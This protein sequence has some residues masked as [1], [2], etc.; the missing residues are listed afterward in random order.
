MKFLSIYILLL[1][2]TVNAQFTEF[3]PELDWFTIK[4]KYVDVHYHSEAERTARTVAKIADEVWEPI[5]S[6]YGYEP[7]RVHF[8]IKD[9]DDYSN[10]AAYFFDNKIEIWTSAL[11]FDLRG[12][13]NWLRNVISHEFTHMVQIQASLKFSRSIPAVYLQWLNYEDERRP[14]I[15]YGFPNIIMSYPYAFV[16]IPAWYAEGTAQY[17]RKE[18]GYDYWDAHRDMILRSY[19]LD[20]NL[21]TWNQMGVFGKTSLGNESAY[22]AGFA[23]IKYIAQKYGEA[24]LV[25]INNALRKLKNITIDGA[26][27]D[28]LGISGEELYNEWREFIINDYKKRTASVIE[29]K[30]EGEMIASVGFGN[31]HP[32]FSEDGKKVFYISNKNGDYF[33]SSGIYQF[34]I[35]T[36]N[37]ELIV[38]GVRSTFD[39]IPG[40]NKIIFSK[41]SDDNPHW[42]NVNDLYVYDINTKKQ[43]RLTYN[44]RA[45][46]PSVSPDGKNIIF[47][48]QR[49]GSTNLGTVD[50]EGKNFRQIT[51]YQYGEQV[52]NPKF[53]PDNKLIIFDYSFEDARKIATIKFD[54][55]DLKFI[56]ESKHDE[57]NA[58][59]DKEGNIIYSSN[60]TGIFNIY[61]LNINSNEKTQLTNV[62]GGAF[63]PS[64]NKEGNITYAGYTSTGYKIFHLE[65][66]SRQ[67]INKE[68]NYV[69]IENPPLGKDKP[70]GDLEKFDL[71]SL[72]KYNDKILPE[73]DKVKYG[74]AF[75]KLTVFPF[76]RY[77]NYNP[78]NTAIE[79]IKPGVYL[80]SSDML[81][82]Y[83]F[84]AGGAINSRMERDLFLIFDYKNKLPI[85]YSL[86]IKPEVSIELYNITRKADVDVLLNPDTVGNIVKY[87][88]SIPTDVTYNLF[89]FDFVAKHRMFSRNDELEFRFIFSRYNAAIGSFFIPNLGLYPTT[90]DT[91]LIG[92]NFQ[93]K[94]NFASIKPSVDMNI[95]PV[96]SELELIYNYELNKFNIDN[97]YTVEDGI[98]KSVFQ[99]FNFHR[100]ELNSKLHFEVFKNHTLTTRVR[101][102]TVLGPEVPDFFDFYLGGL[103]GMKSYPFYA[104]S[105]NEVG[106]FNITYRF[107]LFRNIDSRVGHLYIDKIFFSL[108]GDIGNAWTGEIPKLNEFKKGA[109]AEL[110]IGLNSFYLFPTSVFINASYG[111]DKV[112]RIVRDEL[113]TYG[114]EFRF[115]G[116]ILFG[117]DF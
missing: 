112:E 65:N 102:G 57:R 12:T 87:D 105:G 47:V 16:N 41:L 62:T 96:G 52:Y 27:K 14:D 94:Y 83:S 98:L 36:K 5:T 59:Y 91:Y 90:D 23:L 35:E 97:E 3:H 110:R 101:A 74:G 95:N 116:G 11:D 111:F 55:S 42:Y 77:D 8:V 2:I 109:G 30:V 73:Y 15:L 21:L 69:V 113:I 39:F 9:I 24:K 37:D 99:N 48:F 10:G 58:I 80:T 78:S 71:V 50:I 84:F 25:E 76:L 92:R 86:G 1:S 81:N 100:L 45:N 40:E 93:L 19:A 20:N 67:I 44:L 31:F 117:F 63:M 75:S 7:E 28:A 60:E 106:W 61:K 70:L 103:I 4:G 18:F 114:K 49:D 33:G 26:I 54:G 107:P 38:A 51:F 43:T 79:K 56:N 66:S 17:M 32:I 82:R 64:I 68:F 22:N 6:L 34:D 13:H 53:S 115:Y 104:I 108:Y 89:E 72:Q 85:L 46:N 29:N 88:L